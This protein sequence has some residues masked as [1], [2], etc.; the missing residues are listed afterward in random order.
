VLSDALI[1]RLQKAGYQ[2]AKRTPGRFIHKTNSVVFFLFVDD[3]GVKYTDKKDA[4]HL[5]DTL[6]QDY[7]ITEDWEGSNYCG[8]DLDWNYE[9]G[10]AD[11]SM[12][13]YVKRALQR[14]ERPNPVKPQHAPSKWAE[15]TYGAKVQMADNEDTSLVTLGSP[16]NSTIILPTQSPIHLQVQQQ[17]HQQSNPY[18]NSILQQH[19]PK[20][21]PKSNSHST[22]THSCQPA[23]PE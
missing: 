23:G 10:W 5:R 6:K 19:Q 14:F 12:D 2:P 4:E 17:P 7:T 21:Q 1:P 20:H 15:P 8:L 22:A 18:C 16:I 3:F 13:G 9:E 11:I